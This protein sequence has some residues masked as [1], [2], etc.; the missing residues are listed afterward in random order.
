[1]IARE[2]YGINKWNDKFSEYLVERDAV[3][4][5]YSYI[6]KVIEE[7]RASKP[8]N[9][10]SSSNIKNIK[11]ISNYANVQA[12]AKSPEVSS[13]SQAKGNE[14]YRKTRKSKVIENIKINRESQDFDELSA[15][16]TSKGIDLSSCQFQNSKVNINMN[17]YM[18]F[19]LKS[20][21]ECLE[22][23]FIK[24]DIAKQQDLNLENANIYSSEI[25]GSVSPELNFDYHKALQD[26][27]AIEPLS[28]QVK[29]SD[30]LSKTRKIFQKT[31][32]HK[33]K[34]SLHEIRGFEKK[35]NEVNNS[36]GG[37]NFDYSE[38]SKN[39]YSLPKESVL[40]MKVDYNDYDQFNKLN[41]NITSRFNSSKN[42]AQLEELEHS[43]SKQG[44][45][46]SKSVF[47]TYNN[48][49]LLN[50]GGYTNK[51]LFSYQILSENDSFY[52][53]KKEKSQK[54]E[55][56]RASPDQKN[57][58]Y[59]H[60]LSLQYNS[61]IL[62]ENDYYHQST[63]SKKILAGTVSNKKMSVNGSSRLDKNSYEF[64]SASSIKPSNVFTTNINC[65]NGLIGT[66]KNIPSFYYGGK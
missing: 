28:E 62:N 47:S 45:G 33:T 43:S 12:E 15:D 56:Y 53:S 20:N 22:A 25:I 2:R 48:I 65:V 26:Y 31:E 14:V 44:A 19:N 18:N 6:F 3:E 23:N 37:F 42:N 1:M 46:C 40:N 58:N 34:H 24:E 63:S 32:Y 59:H 50:K 5:Y 7:S 30:I 54:R 49:S 36:F 61:R 52:K 51:D 64:Y 55:K 27:N 11:D 35:K 9:Y 39:L 66:G 10:K 38:L 41:A 57:D 8:K 16:Q 13:Q 29:S 21:D 4:P 60:K 17:M